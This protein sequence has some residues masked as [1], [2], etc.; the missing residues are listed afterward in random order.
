MPEWRTKSK[1]GKAV[2][3]KDGKPIRFAIEPH[4]DKRNLPTALQRVE[5]VQELADAIN[6]RRKKTAEEIE[7]EQIIESIV[8]EEEEQKNILDRL[9]DG[10]ARVDKVIKKEQKRAEYKAAL[11]EV[12]QEHLEDDVA[13][14]EEGYGQAWAE[15]IERKRKAKRDFNPLMEGDTV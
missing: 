5:P 11:D 14:I 6:S 2:R 4:G 12:K 13:A 8:N 9:K 7:E 10:L 3:D 1:N 15:D